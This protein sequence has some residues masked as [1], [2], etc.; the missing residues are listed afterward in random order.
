MET[1]QQ[2]ITILLPSAAV[3]YAMYLTVNSFLKKDFEKKTLEAN[4]SIKN[5]SLEYVVPARLQAYERICLL[6]ERITPSNLI[7]RVNQQGFSASDL[8]QVMLQEI[9][10]EF[11]HNYSQQVYMSEQSWVY[12]REV[13]EEL[14]TIINQA[15]T[16]LPEGASSIDLA[17]VIMAII[18]ERGVEPTAPVLVF[19]KEEIRQIF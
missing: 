8:H 13:V 11:G 15:F 12:V 18:Q 4:A 2:F 1:L 19:V 5:K 9:R 3:L 17:T 14:N 6:L 16:Q 10:E 7:L